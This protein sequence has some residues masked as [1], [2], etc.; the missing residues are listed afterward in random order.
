MHTRSG[1][2]AMSRPSALIA[3]DKPLVRERLVAQLSRLWP[4][5]QLVATARNGREALELFERHRPDVVF[6]DLQ[7]PGQSGIDTAR[8]IGRRALVVFVTVF[9]LYAVQAFE[10]GALDYL[11][12]PYG[13]VRLADTVQR[14]QQR[15]AGPPLADG[16][17]ALH[18]ALDRLAAEL[19]QHAAPRAF[20][21]WIKA[22]VGTT[23]RL[24]PVDEVAHLRSGETYTL[25]VWQGGEALIRSTIRELADELDPSAS[26]R[27]TAR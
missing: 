11:V 23:L 1:A 18:E 3:D 4:Q 7:T 10:D 13:Q 20:R 8:A 27:C 2:V 14:L 16:G 24:I 26:C 25:V 15:V 9:E 17:S 6:L 5:L 19:R 21:H 22:S 12:K